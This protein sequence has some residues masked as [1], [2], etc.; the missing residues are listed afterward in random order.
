MDER[1][2]FDLVYDIGETLLKNGAEIKRIETTIHHIAKA[3]ELQEFDSFVLINGIFMTARLKD[4]TVQARV[5]DV[6]ISPI[7]LG[8]IEQ[9]NTLSRRLAEKR[10]SPEEANQWLQEIKQQTFSSNPLK[11]FAYA[12]GSASFCFIFGGSIWDTMG[13]LLLGVILACFTMYLLPKF[14]MSDIILTITS[15]GFV[16][17]LAC[18]FVHFVPILQLTSLI[19]GGIIS[20]LP[21]VAIVNGIR[22]LFDGDYSSGWGQMINALITALCVSVGVGLVLRVF[23]ML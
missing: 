12:F 15:S 6:P 7:N 1:E 23:S 18:L 2:A 16:S 17:I 14:N 8:R 13:A 5:R 11:I 3:L 21:G 19:T 20:L 9:I 22:Y 4:Q 10:L